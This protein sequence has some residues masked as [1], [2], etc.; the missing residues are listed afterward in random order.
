[1]KKLL[2]PSIILACIIPQAIAYT[3][4]DLSAANFLAKEWI[5]K[6]WNNTP[7]KFELDNNITRREMLKVMMNLSWLEVEDKCDWSFKDLISSD[8]WCKYAEKALKWSFIASNEIFRPD[9]SITKI[10][11]LKLIMQ[12]KYLAKT[13]AE[14]W[15]KWYVEAAFNAWII[16]ETFEDYNTLATRAWIFNIWANTY[17]NFITDEE[18]IINILEEI[19]K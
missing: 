1:M 7:E 5:I 17:D 3:D 16:N 15:R 9:D 14:D 19:F 2:L 12:A 10:E 4:Y 8:W 18:E 6:D 11:S 13:Q